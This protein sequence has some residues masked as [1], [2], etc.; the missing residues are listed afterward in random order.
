M[1]RF[2]IIQPELDRCYICGRQ[3]VPLNKHE[4]FYGTANR[5]KSIKW[6][7]VVALC[8]EHHTGSNDAVHLNR[9]VDIELKRKAQKVFEERYGHEKFMSV[10]HHNYL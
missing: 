3:G 10:F 7:M 4:V 8:V 2:S 5:S 9:S 1:K 6:G